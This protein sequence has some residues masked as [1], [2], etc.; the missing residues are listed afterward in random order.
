MKHLW[1]KP[2]RAQIGALLGRNPRHQLARRYL[3]GSGIEIGALHA[4]LP[5]PRAAKVRYL[6]RMNVSEL[7]RQ[8][9]ELAHEALVEPDIIDDG[10]TM[11]RVAD[12]S[13]DFL[14]ANH[15]IEHCQDTLGTL[16]HW[17]RVLKPGGVLYMAVPDKR[18]TFDLQRPTTS[19]QHLQRDHEHGPALSR[20]EHYQ[21]WARLVNNAPEHQVAAAAQALSDLDYSIHFHVWTQAEFLKTLLLCRDELCLRF[22]IEALQHNGLEFIVMLRKPE[23]L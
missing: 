15:V 5:V 7:R 9:A 8:Y 3:K 10:E 11:S 18:F 6:D 21:E 16:R 22:E 2:L 19:W 20:D 4:P 14:I 1:L 12:D 13:Q 23:K 17:L